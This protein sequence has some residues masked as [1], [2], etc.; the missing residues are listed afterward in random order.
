M[1]KL[2]PQSMQEAILRLVEGEV[3]T[4]YGDR[5][6]FDSLNLASP[7]RFNDKPLEHDWEFFKEWQ[8]VVEWYDPSR[9]ASPRLC[10]VWSGTGPNPKSVAGYVKMRLHDGRY[11]TT[12]GSYWHNATPVDPDE[13]GGKQYV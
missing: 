12:A 10:W 9:T 6:W 8:P 5:I 1:D 3:F 4:R 11:S 2:S 13:L 7:F